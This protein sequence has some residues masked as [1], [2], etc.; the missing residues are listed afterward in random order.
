M[1][2]PCIFGVKTIFINKQTC[3]KQMKTTRIISISIQHDLPNVI[4]NVTADDWFKATTV[5]AIFSL[6]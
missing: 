5:T 6:T 2:R 1:P 3:L 4:K